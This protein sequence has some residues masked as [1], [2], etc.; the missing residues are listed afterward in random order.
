VRLFGELIQPT[1]EGTLP[2]QPVEPI[3]RPRQDTK[4]LCECTG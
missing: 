2:F 4:A 3:L 1:N